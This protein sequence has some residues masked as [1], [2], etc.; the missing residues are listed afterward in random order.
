MKPLKAVN[1]GGW[2]VL[3]KWMKPS[4]FE[5][6]P[7]QARCETSFVNNHPHAKEALEEHWKTWIVQDDIRWLKNQGI[8]VVRIPIPWWL[9][10]EKYQ[11][12]HPYVTPVHYLD[13]AMDFIHQ[14]GMKVMLDLHTAPGSQNGF[15]NGGIDGV[16]TWHQDPKNIDIT[17]DVLEDIATRY[18]NH[19]ALHSLQVLNEPHWTIDMAL[20]QDFYV[21]A[22]QRLRPI[23]KP[24]T[25]IVFHDSFRFEPWKEFFTKNKMKNVILDTHRYQCFGEQFHKM[26]PTE[27]L[28]FP[29]TIVKE[30]K[31]MEKVVPVI[32]GEW[33]LGARQYEY[34]DGREAFE[35]AFAKAQL[36]AYN[37]ITGWVFWS[38]K[39]SDYNSGWNFRGLVERDILKP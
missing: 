6:Y 37:Q 35:K 26:E 29:K 13:Q 21:R 27:F 14:E 31:D 38:Y 23:L 8:E 25:F 15:D 9:F 5:Q 3:E 20:M 22:Y 7:I 24:E 17:L 12:P 16:L 28:N 4:L 39:I 36:D 33:S 10:P 2:F 18:K 34:K 1:L 11:F 19:P 30:M 32:V